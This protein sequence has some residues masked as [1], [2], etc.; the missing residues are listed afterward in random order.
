[1]QL[2]HRSEQLWWIAI[3]L[4]RTGG[5]RGTESIFR[6]QGKQKEVSESGSN[7]C[8]IEFFKLGYISKI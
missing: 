3:E 1:M 8:C 6:R 7:P 2:T 5:T 4:G